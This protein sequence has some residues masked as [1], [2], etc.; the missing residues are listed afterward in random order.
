MEHAIN[1][2]LALNTSCICST[3][4]LSAKNKILSAQCRLFFCYAL[5]GLPSAHYPLFTQTKQTTFAM[6]LIKTVAL[7]CSSI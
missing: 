5:V 6:L 3:R 4:Y 2:A 1:L 7:L